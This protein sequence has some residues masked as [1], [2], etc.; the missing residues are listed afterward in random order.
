[1]SVPFNKLNKRKKLAIVLSTLMVLSL[2]LAF[3]IYNKIRYTPYIPSKPAQ[4]FLYGEQHGEKELYEKEFELWQHYYEHDGMR[5]LFMEQPYYTAEFLNLWMTRD[6]DD[7]LDQLYAC[8]EGTA[9]H[10]PEVKEFYKKIKTYCPETI[11]LG[12][13]VGHQYGS[14]GESYLNYLKQSGEDNSE[15]YQIAQNTINQGK[16]YYE[17]NDDVYRENAMTEN[18]IKMYDQLNG[19]KI[20]GIYGGAHTD[21]RK[22]NWNHKV[23]CM[24]K[25]LKA[26]YGDVI[27]YQ[28]V[29]KVRK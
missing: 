1:M 24:A 16:N 5:Y 9:T 11:F 15:K 28:E 14:I 13:D 18:F 21:P 27:E 8:W 10:V 25:Q 26:Y 20:M 22:K 7:I 3:V 29:R 19:A 6:D 4:I 23:D 17:T 2:I 12:T